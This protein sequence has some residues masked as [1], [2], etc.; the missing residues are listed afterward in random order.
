MDESYQEM[1]MH[2][3]PSRNKGTAEVLRGWLIFG[4]IVS[5]LVHVGLYIVLNH[6]QLR[7][8]DQSHYRQLLPPSFRVSQVTISEEA[9]QDPGADPMEDLNKEAERAQVDPSRFQEEF[10]ENTLLQREVKMSPEEKELSPEL[11][12]ETLRRPDTTATSEIEN[13]RESAGD[14]ASDIVAGDLARELTREMSEQDKSKARQSELAE[15]LRQEVNANRSSNQP[16]LELEDPRE[17]VVLSG[18]EGRTEGSSIGDGFNT[19]DG[20]SDIDELLTQTGP[21]E[22]DTAPLMMS[23]DVMFDSDSYQLKRNALRSLGKLGRL[24]RKHPSV[25]F[26]VEGHTDSFGSNEYNQR[27][28]E[29]RAESVKQWLVRNMG[30]DPGQVVT[31][32]YGETQLIAPGSGTEEQQQIN[33]R[34]EILMQGLNGG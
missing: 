28:S 16:L 30:I 23:G 24:M 17:Q 25:R 26:V 18:N 7:G 1:N 2:E 3:H 10:D 11:L 14:I 12:K 13:L 31:R 5:I 21:L 8:L 34:V 6:L 22:A 20:Y 15:Q 19:P 33:R 9:L 27:L 32:G 29:M 4:L